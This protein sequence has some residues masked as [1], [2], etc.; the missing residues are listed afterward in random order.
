MTNPYEKTMYNPNDRLERAINELEGV[1][2]KKEYGLSDFRMLRL[3]PWTSDTHTIRKFVEADMMGENVLK[4]KVTGGG[5]QT[6]YAIE[7]GNIIIYLKRFGA[8]LIATARKPR[9]KNGR[10]DKVAVDKR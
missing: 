8:A 9:K 6:R 10:P 4:A 3:L 5:T 2:P 7:A 1:N